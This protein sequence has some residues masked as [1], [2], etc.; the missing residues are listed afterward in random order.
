[1]KCTSR[2]LVQKIRNLLGGRGRSSKDYIGLQGGG[3]GSPKKDYVIFE[4][5]LVAVT[6]GKQSQILISRL[7][8]ELDNSNCAVTV[9]F[10]Q[11]N[12]SHYL[13]IMSSSPV[14]GSHFTSNKTECPICFSKS[15][16]H[17]MHCWFIKTSLSMYVIK[18]GLKVP[19]IIKLLYVS[20][21]MSY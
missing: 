16:I 7:W 2:I 1:M 20:E 9:Y 8:L 10:L 13:V 5:S 6:G 19:Q 21:S 17:I 11:C 4:W 3:L 15:K 14:S 12:N 18:I